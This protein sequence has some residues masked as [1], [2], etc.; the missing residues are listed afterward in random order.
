MNRILRYFKNPTKLKKGDRY[1]KKLKSFVLY[2]FSFF[3]VIVLTLG[4]IM[5]IGVLQDLL[6]VPN[7]YLIWIFKYPTNKLVFIYELYAIIAF[8]SVLNKDFREYI[9]ER[10]KRSAFKK[11]F[12]ATFMI[13]NIVVFYIIMTSVTVIK[14]DGLIDYSFLSPQGK[15][16]SYSDIV[17]I[18]TGVHG[19][20]YVSFSHSKGDFFYVIELR[21]GTEIDLNDVG[22]SGIDIDHRFIIEELDIKLVNMGIP[23]NASMENFEYVT[24]NLAK[25]YT[26]KIKNILENT[27]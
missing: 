21:D 27:H 13:F 26:D 1:L 11:Q 23:K 25:T 6:F 9:I 24:K 4:I 3:A 19:K 8:I 15:K 12:I 20:N 5:I 7:D 10:Y 17:E 14:S 18:N 2:V 22:G 16:F